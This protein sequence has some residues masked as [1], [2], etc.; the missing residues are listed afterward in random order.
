M[1]FAPACAASLAMR[2][3]LTAFACTPSLLPIF[4]EHCTAATRTVGLCPDMAILCERF[5]H[6]W[7]LKD[8]GLEQHPT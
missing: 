3:I 1:I 8:S 7:R 4:E 6:F 2:S 5:Y